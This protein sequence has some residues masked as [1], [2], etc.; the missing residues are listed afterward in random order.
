MKVLTPAALTPH[1]GSLR[2]LR[3]AFRA[4]RSQPL[5]G[6]AQRFDRH[7]SLSTSEGFALQSQARRTIP[8]KRIRQPTGYAFASCCSPPRLP[9]KERKPA[10]TTVERRSY[11]RLHMVW[12]H[13]TG[14]R[15]PLTR[16]PHGRTIASLS[17][18]RNKRASSQG[19]PVN[20][21]VG[22]IGI[23]CR[24]NGRRLDSGCSSRFLPAE[25]RLTYSANEGDLPSDSRGSH[26][27]IETAFRSD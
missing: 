7:H 4:S 11:S 18:T 26:Y 22:V 1:G 16:R 12:L 27:F 14:T 2:L 9:P 21:P 25:T 10:R 13:A 3:P 17:L 23:C 15:T 6:H 8:P 5:D 24:C 20:Q 19:R